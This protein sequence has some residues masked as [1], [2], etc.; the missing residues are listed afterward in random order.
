MFP[1]EQL[2][3]FLFIAGS[4]L[5][6]IHSDNTRLLMSL[7][8][9][10]KNKGNIP[11]NKGLKLSEIQKLELKSKI[12]HRFNP[13]YFYDEM[14]NLVTMYESFNETRRKEKCSANTLLNC[15]KENKL[16]RGYKVTY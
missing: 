6:N 13:V 14:N 5:G 15:I 3:N 8:S 10:G 4:P 11:I 1:K 2:Y 12:K 16:F 7:N 9:K